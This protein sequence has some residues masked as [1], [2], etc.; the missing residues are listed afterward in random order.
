MKTMIDIQNE[1]NGEW[2]NEMSFCQA[3]CK[4]VNVHD[5]SKAILISNMNIAF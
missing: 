1:E 4:L 2:F 3:I 5:E